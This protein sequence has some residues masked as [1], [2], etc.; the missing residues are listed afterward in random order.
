MRTDIKQPLH[1]QGVPKKTFRK[2]WMIFSNTV[3]EL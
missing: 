2:D 1:I 3:F